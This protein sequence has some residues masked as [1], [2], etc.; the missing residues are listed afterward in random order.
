MLLTVEPK[1][2]LLLQRAI[3]LQTI[4]SRTVSSVL[5]LPNVHLKK[6]HQISLSPGRNPACPPLPH[7]CIIHIKNSTCNA[8]QLWCEAGSGLWGWGGWGCAWMD[9]R[10]ETR[11]GQ[12]SDAQQFGER[13]IFLVLCAPIQAGLFRATR[14]SPTP[15]RVRGRAGETRRTERYNCLLSLWYPRAPR[16]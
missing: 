7:L 14:L 9:E 13:L 11:A 4:S 10:W 15:P 3:I 12:S 2:E 1:L 16:R 5:S 8:G 6:E